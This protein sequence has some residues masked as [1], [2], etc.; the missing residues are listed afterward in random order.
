MGNLHIVAYITTDARKFIYVTRQNPAD[1]PQNPENGST[2]ARNGERQAVG[3]LAKPCLT[4][5]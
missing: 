2:G 5:S 4:T 3:K 1:P